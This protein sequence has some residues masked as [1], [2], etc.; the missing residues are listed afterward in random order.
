MST[1]VKLLLNDFDP[2]DNG[3]DEFNK[4]SDILDGMLHCV[5]RDDS[6]STPIALN[7][8][9]EAGEVFIVA[10][11]PVVGPWS[12]EGGRMA[13]A[14]QTVIGSD[15]TTWGIVSGWIFLTPIQG[16]IAWTLRIAATNDHRQ[17]FNS[18]GWFGG[19]LVA[20]LDVGVDSEATTVSRFNALLT[21]LRG[22]GVIAT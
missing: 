20:D 14:K 16:F 6:E 21:E 3:Q 22:H 19:A 4:I 9:P 5:I 12:G 8:A 2:L 10:G 1:T 15:A 7:P 18:S 17:T 13:I 11:A